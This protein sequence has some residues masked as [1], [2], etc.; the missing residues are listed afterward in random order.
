[1]KKPVTEAIATERIE[2]LCCRSEQCSADIRRKLSLWG[3][4]PDTAD[5]IIEKL[6]ERK[7]IDDSRF[8]RAF[9]RDK[10]RFSGWGR[11]KI[12]T[13]LRTK[14]ISASVVSEALREINLREYADMAFKA[15][16]SKLRTMPSGLTLHD[17]RN[18]LYRF[19]IQRGFESS[20]V[21]RIINSKKLWEE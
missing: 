21:M 18:R 1:M 20:L 11:N 19:G 14:Q 4:T 10:Y 17:I 12:I 15:V 9:V 7:F 8:A 16:K 3:I 2:T 6:R 5:R 13:A